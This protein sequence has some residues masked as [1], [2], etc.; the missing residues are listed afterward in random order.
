M[1]I[2]SRKERNLNNSIVKEATVCAFLFIFLKFVWR[3]GSFVLFIHQ[4]NKKA[5]T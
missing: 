2:K 1:C 3:N 5:E 4:W